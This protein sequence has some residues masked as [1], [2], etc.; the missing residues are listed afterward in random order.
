MKK[1]KL[2]EQLEEIKLIDKEHSI[3]AK[4]SRLKELLHPITLGSG[5]DNPLVEVE[6]R[7]KQSK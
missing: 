7:G 2:I 3:G 6:Y 5:I 4:H 1:A